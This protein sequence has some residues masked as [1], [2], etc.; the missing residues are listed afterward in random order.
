MDYKIASPSRGLAWFRGGVRMLDRDPRGLLTVALGLLLLEQLPGLLIGVPA[1][2][3]TLS[4][5]L[6]LFG[7]ALLAG[8]L[9]AVAE[10]EAGRPVPVTYLF[11]GLR[12]PG[13]RAQL[14]VLGVVALLAM[15]VM[16]LVLQRL[17]TAEQL[18]LFVRIASQ[19]IKADSPEFQAAAPQLL[20]PLAVMMAIVFVLVVGLF[21]AVPRVMFDGKPALAALLESL[22]ACVANTFALLVYGVIFVAAIFA[23]MLA[24][25]VVAMFLGLL[26]QLGMILLQLLALAFFVVVLVVSASGNYL[27]W[28]EV[29]GRRDGPALAEPPRTGIVV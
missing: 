22:V 14:I 1:L 27:A 19:Q 16:G 29:F 26:G 25:G 8:L 4:V 15:L 5:L 3:A 17:L 11:A 20:K 6:L 9:Y 23:A 13:A 28:R 10:A 2:S 7:P 21:F 18:Q 24:L 12:Q